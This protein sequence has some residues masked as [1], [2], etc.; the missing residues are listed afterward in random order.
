M[1]A[2][3]TKSTLFDLTDDEA[4]LLEALIAVEEM[5]DQAPTESLRDEFEVAV[6]QLDA[7]LAA[8]TEQIR[9]KVD[10]YG[11]ILRELARKAEAYRVTEDEFKRKRQVA[12]AAAARLK[13]FLRWAMEDRGD[14][15][16][17]GEQ[18]TFALQRNSQPAV[19]V[20]DEEAALAAG[21]AET[22][23]TI[24]VDRRGIGKAWK[25]DPESVA[26]FAEVA[27]GYHLRMR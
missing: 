11:W 20:T 17:E 9:D 14:T 13:D 27:Q 2:D 23:T 5:A 10:S 12:E 3:P 8:V 24:K 1:A 19:V 15:K 22:V 16:L 25:T 4:G 6:K 7:Q 18:T 26:G 21:L